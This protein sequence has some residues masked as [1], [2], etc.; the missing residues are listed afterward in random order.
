MAPEVYGSTMVYG[1]TCLLS[2]FT[3]YLAGDLQQRHR[4]PL[5]ASIVAGA[6]HRNTPSSSSPISFPFA[7][8]RPIAHL[9]GI[10]VCNGPRQQQ[11]AAIRLDA[12]NPDPAAAPTAPAPAATVGQEGLIAAPAAAAAP[13]AFEPPSPA[14]AAAAMAA[15]AAERPDS[16]FFRPGAQLHLRGSQGYCCDEPPDYTGE[17]L[18]VEV[19]GPLGDGARGSAVQ[20][21]CISHHRPNQSSLT[22]KDLALKLPLPAAVHASRSPDAHLQTLQSLLNLRAA[23]DLWLEH[24]TM[25]KTWEEYESEEVLRSHCFGYGGLSSSSS[26]G[27][28]PFLLTELA[29][30]R[31]LD[32]Y[33]RGPLRVGGLPS[34]MTH[35]F[36]FRVVRGVEALH[37]GADTVHRD[38]KCSNLLMFRDYRGRLYPKI[39]DFKLSKVVADMDM[40]PRTVV[41]TPGHRAPEV[42]W[43]V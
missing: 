29:E 31:S 11:G 7:M 24:E 5:P 40:L 36:M 19:V 16:M 38:L 23:R 22:G 27:P 12:M 6:F 20:V 18:Y 42:R 32:Q 9:H 28:V 13:F 41:G 37:V 34:N 15:A 30:A 8:G 43:E 35:Q 14:A 21:V 3:V 25:T 39:A 4:D 10:T 26:S 33:L 1:S 17:E 2:P